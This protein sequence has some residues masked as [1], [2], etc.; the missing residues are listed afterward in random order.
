MKIRKLFTFS[1]YELTILVK[2][3]CLYLKWDILISKFHYK[4]WQASLAN[5]YSN[6]YTPNDAVLNTN[7]VKQ[8]Q[9]IINIIRIN[10]SA[11]RN[12]FRHMNCLRRCL[13]QQDLLSGYGIQCKLHLGVKFENSKLAAHSWLSVNGEVINDSQEVISTYKELTTVNDAQTLSMLK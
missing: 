11:G 9:S 1:W 8:H 4:K 12:H 6:T 10:E 2:S 13:C 3:W 7:P 5:T